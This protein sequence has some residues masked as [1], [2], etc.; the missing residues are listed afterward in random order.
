MAEETEVPE[1][2]EETA[3]LL[4]AAMATASVKDYSEMDLYRD[5]RRVFFESEEGRRVFRVLLSWGHLFRPSFRGATQIDPIAM[6]VRE[7]ERN[8]ALRLLATVSHEPQSRPARA[9]TKP[10]KD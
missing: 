3:T 4:S 6:A 7:G 1:S 8:Y 9:N 10:N 2:P 5:M